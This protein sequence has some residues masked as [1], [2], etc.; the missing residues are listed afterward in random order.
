MTRF[1]IFLCLIGMPL[2]FGQDFSANHVDGR[3]TPRLEWNKRDQVA[4]QGLDA[5]WAYLAQNAVKYGIDDLNQ[6]RFAGV[7]HSLVGSHYAF[8]QMLDGVPVWS[9]QI[10]VSLAY[11]DGS[12]YQVSNN[13]FPVPER[14]RSQMAFLTEDDAYELAWSHLGVT[15]PLLELPTSQLVFVPQ[16]GSFI[17]S[18]VNQIFVEQPFGYWEHVIDAQ[19]GEILSWRDTALTRKPVQVELGTEGPFLNR[20]SELNRFRRRQAAQSEMKAAVL[21]MG[22][23]SLFDPDPRTSLKDE[24][25][26]DTS[27]ASAFTNAYFPRTLLDITNNAGTFSLVGPWVQIIDFEPPATPP[28]TT[29]NGNWSGFQRGNNAF[30]DAMTYFH[31]DQSQRH[32]QSLGFT[33]ATGIQELSIGADSDGFNGEDNSHYLSGPNRLAFGHGCVDDNE[34]Q[35]VILHE[36]GHAIHFGINGNNWSDGDTGAMGEGFGDFWAGSYKYVSPNGPVFRPEWAFPWDARVTCWSGRIL[37]LTPGPKYDFAHNYDAHSS[38]M[39]VLGDELWS[40]PLYQALIQ[41][42]QAGGTRDSVDQIVLE[43]HFGLAAGAKMRDLGN[44]I[45]QAAKTLQPNGPHAR[46]FARQ[47]NSFNITLIPELA[48]DSL[49]ITDSGGNGV[50]DPGDQVDLDI[51]LTN[52]GNGPS[53][54]I[55][56]QLTALSPFVSVT[57]NTASYSDLNPG[58]PGTGSMPFSFTTSA[59]N[60]C[61]EPLEFLLTVT[62]AQETYSLPVS[63]PVGDNG[64]VQTTQSSPAVAIPDQGMVSDTLTLTG[65][66]HF[67][68]PS[69][70]VDIDITHTYSGDLEIYLESPSGTQVALYLHAGGSSN[71]VIG[72]FPMTLTPAA[73]MAAFSGEPQDGTWTLHVMDTSA[74]E[75]GTLNSWSIHYVENVICDHCGSLSMG[76][77]YPRWLDPNQNV[78]INDYNGNG[79]IDLLDLVQFGNFDCGS[80]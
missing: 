60:T 9:G 21:A 1:R 45:V 8:Q 50:V 61:G 4:G 51:D 79:H 62:T 69:F 71:N 41:I 28:S 76:D 78:A 57:Q 14:F 39:G 16:D 77:L 22:Q 2:A 75:T 54:G 64:T 43:A 34:D 31:I 20:D 44:L 80:M 30:N 70:S 26:V 56:A 3:E 13:V 66:N 52:V 27:P 32:I 63:V 53:T 29:N 5:A 74:G 38:W 10:V 72:N 59:A 11:Q 23:A 67:V 65:T 48:L 68:L 40:T 6:L 17:L 42:L 12:V 46:I 47:F 35:F 15:G 49:A 36:Y 55:S 24:T 19:T 37:N 25:L 58:A 18:Y 33:G 7:K 73:S